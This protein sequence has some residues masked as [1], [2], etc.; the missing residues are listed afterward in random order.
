MKQCGFN[1]THFGDLE[2][3]HLSGLMFAQLDVCFA[4][5]F[6]IHERKSLC[7]SGGKK[8]PT[9]KLFGFPSSQYLLNIIDSLIHWFSRMGA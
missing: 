5:H 8:C 1:G 9:D 4:G 2:T 7:I 6:T 3:T